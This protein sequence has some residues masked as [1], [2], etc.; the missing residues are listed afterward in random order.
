MAYLTKLQ[1]KQ[2]LDQAPPNLDK[3]KIVESLVSQ[4][5]ELEGFNDVPKQEGLIS[6]VAKGAVKAVANPFL[7]L[8]ATADALSTSKYLGGA[9]TDNTAKKTPVGDIKPITTAK[10]AVGVGA[11]LGATGLGFGGLG[12]TGRFGAKLLGSALVGGLAGAGQKLQQAESTAKGVIKSAAAGAAIGGALPV[13][14]EALG[15]AKRFLGAAAKGTAASISGAGSDAIQA[16][17]DNPKAAQAGLREDATGTLKNISSTIRGKVS[18][19]A[20]EAQDEYSASIANLPKRLG[21][22]P[23][24]LTAGQKTT[25]KV[26]GQTYKLSMQGVK[27]NLTSQL[28]KFGVE[29]NP[30]KAEFDFLEAPFVG[31]EEQ[32]LK[33]VFDVVQKWKDTTPEGLNKLAIKVGQYR[34]SGVQSPEL[35]SVIDATKKGVRDYIGKRVPAVAEL[36][37]KY[38]QVQDFI[39][40]I[41]QELATNGKFKGGTTE[42][43][44]TAKKISTIFNKNKDL[45]REL[46]ARLEGGNEILGK[47]AGRE[48]SAGVSRSSASIGDLTK[49]AIQS[50]I[51]PR[52]IGE[53]AAATGIAHENLAPILAGLKNLQPA[54]RILLIQ[55]LN[56]GINSQSDESQA[57]SISQEQELQ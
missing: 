38:S 45:A 12:T 8:G 48:L 18:N 3:G 44:N 51:P 10:D 7:R 22:N 25:I 40:A 17:I 52:A 50:I 16:V 28:R 30:K 2:I 32:T 43:I 14:G 21:R 11:E 42:Q 47:E 31:G 1:V 39:D 54:E 9:G 41:D 23:E 4:G 57:D 27:A 24:V 20:K 56:H 46:V 13:A 26:G 6:K 36:N 37:S 49:G 35:N 33:K 29:V 15:L 19:L 34:K 53:V 55:L 5:N